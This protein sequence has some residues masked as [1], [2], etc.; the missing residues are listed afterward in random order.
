VAVSHLV[1]GHDYLQGNA[2][3][4]LAIVRLYRKEICSVSARQRSAS[5]APSSGKE[6]LERDSLSREV[7]LDAAR[8]VAERDGLAGLTFQAIGSELRAH[9]T[10]IYR[11][12][13][14]KDEL[15][16]DLID[17]LRARSY[18]GKLVHSTDWRD[19]MR[20]IARLIHDHYLRYP[21]FALQ[22]AAR[23]TRR[24]TEFANVEFGARALL[25]A[26]L[27][28]ASAAICLRAF[29]NYVRSAAS[30]EASMLNLDERTRRAD[31]LA[32][33]VEYRHLDP[34]QFPAISEL[35]GSLTSI[36]DPD[37]FWTGVELMLDGIAL[38]AERE[39][40]GSAPGRKRARAT[41]QA[42]S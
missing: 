19:D 41:G 4:T 3:G 8:A 11:H 15:L 10:S 22:M 13:R 35:D 12:F 20:L 32:W 1:T 2:L 36:G 16:L 29:G 6:R 23:T 33:E 25:K 26:G 27:S 34:E 21:S 40:A 30:I 14:D 17:D 31:N 9:P 24:P 39:A 5:R 37:A 38:R 42:S 18:G 28:P 7:I